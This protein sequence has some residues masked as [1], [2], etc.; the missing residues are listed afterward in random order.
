MKQ[1]SRKGFTLVELMVMVGLVAIIGAMGTNHFL[2]IFE[3]NRHAAIQADAER[4]VGALNAFN[5]MARGPGQYPGDSRVLA[6]VGTTP[7]R[8]VPWNGGTGIR[9]GLIGSC[10]D[11]P[12]RVVIDSVA[13]NCRFNDTSCGNTHEI[14]LMHYVNRWYTHLNPNEVFGSTGTMAADFSLSIDCDHFVE[15]LSEASPLIGI[16][17]DRWIVLP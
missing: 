4:L 3:A 16:V 14:Q 15:I 10:G 8:Y 5:A 6:V 7:N 11:H 12:F 1:K 2:G 9:R 13:E 17:N